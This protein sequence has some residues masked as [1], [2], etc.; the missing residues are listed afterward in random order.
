MKKIKIV[1]I[2]A[3]VLLILLS[4]SLTNLF[5]NAATSATDNQAAID[6][7]VAET[8]AAETQNSAPPVQ[9]NPPADV[10]DTMQFTPTVTLTTTSQVPM[11]S[12]STDTN[13][14]FGPG[15]IYDYMGAFTVGQNAEVIG[16][17]AASDYWVIRLP[18]TPSITCWIWGQYATV[19]GNTSGIPIIEPP[20]TPTP[21]RTPTRTLPPPAAAPVLT[22]L[23]NSG[24]TIF[25]VYFSLST[26]SAWGPDQLGSAVISS[27]SSYSWTISPGT[28]DIKL[29]DSGHNVLRTWFSQSITSNVTYSYP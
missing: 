14:R 9:Q 6:Q 21:S 29:E 13:C 28:Y 5:N 1:T 23:N 10:P 4:C 11:V 27:G 25:Y 15:S 19:I 12:V 2:S 22:I 16:R 20:P 3:L 17:S 7:A 26:S 18:S 24:T 8:M